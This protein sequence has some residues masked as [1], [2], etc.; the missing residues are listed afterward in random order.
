M[1][2][3]SKCDQDHRISRKKENIA[4]GRAFVT[5]S[6]NSPLR[7]AIANALPSLLSSMIY[8]CGL[9]IVGEWRRLRAEHSQ[10][11]I[12]AKFTNYGGNA[13]PLRES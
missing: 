11:E 3:V 8:P 10:F 1:L 4:R 12:I 5:L 6:R 13:L 2:S 9:R 7:S